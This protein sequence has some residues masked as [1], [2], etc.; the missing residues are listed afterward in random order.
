MSVKTDALELSKQAPLE[1]VCKMKQKRKS[2][3]SS[4]KYRRIVEHFIYTKRVSEQ[5]KK[6]TRKDIKGRAV[7]MTWQTHCQF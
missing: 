1:I 3:E 2:A 5:I 6:V 7:T 4:S